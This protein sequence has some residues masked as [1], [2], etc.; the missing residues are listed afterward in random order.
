MLTIDTYLRP[1]TLEEAYAALQK[2]NSAVLG[3]MMW[4]RLGNRR[5]GTAIDLSA[6]GLDQIEDTGDIWKI[7]AY[8]TLRTLETHCELHKEFH[9]VLRD[10]VSSIV[11][12]QFRNL[13]TVGGSIFGR[14]GFS[15]IVTTFL[16]LGASVEFYHH[17]TVTL[18]EFCG[19]G[20]MHDIL[21]HICIPKSP[22]AA[23]YKSQ[24]NTA[25]DFPVLNTC[26]VLRDNTITVTVGA[27]PLRAVPYHFC[28]DTAGHADELAA[29]IAGQIADDT[30][31]ASNTRA[32]A[33]YRKHL[34]NVL[35]RRAVLDILQNKETE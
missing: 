30:V 28:I 25:T 33:E 16:A 9:G 17:G 8:T 31:F 34:C 23:S 21:T 7:G 4:M 1:E 32:S 11:G 13:A 35:V 5:I 14:Y 15:D 20:N 10:S 6:L 29:S 24:R 19:M 27:R 12:V 2:K 26:A 18:E 22:S 3:G